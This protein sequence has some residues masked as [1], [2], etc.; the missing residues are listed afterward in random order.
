[1]KRVLVSA[2]LLGQPVRYDG[3]SV[4]VESSLL[5]K[6]KSEGR[7]ISL[8]PELSAGF[9]VPRA[10]AEIEPGRDGEDVLIGKAKILEDTGVD[11]TDV[12]RNAAML[13]VD[14]ARK[15]GCVFAVL[16]DGSPS[17]GSS[18]IYSGKF[19]GGRRDGQGV[20]AAAL[21]ANGVKVFNQNQ[22]SE[23]ADVLRHTEARP[24]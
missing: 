15:N 21:R 11:V 24:N 20:V 10:P 16:T 8:C 13:A 17:C 3:S 12:F 1:M 4:S 19:D 22:I 23:L 2:C 9:S 14:V 18:Y 7:L 6:W 5:H